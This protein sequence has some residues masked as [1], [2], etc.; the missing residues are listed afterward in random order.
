MWISFVTTLRLSKWSFLKVSCN[1][2]SETIVLKF[3]SVRLKPLVYLAF[4][5][6]LFAQVWLFG[7]TELCTSSTADTVCSIISMSQYTM[8]T[9]HVQNY[10]ISLISS[11]KVRTGMLSRLQGQMQVF[12]SHFSA[13]KLK[14]IIEDKYGQLF[15][16]KRQAYLVHVEKMSANSL[17][18]TTTFCQLF[19]QIKLVFHGEK[20]G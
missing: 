10:H 18:W 7:I 11:E 4:W 20:H 19:F 9:N 6:G 15:S 2:E 17:V 13:R 3:H 5:I 12:Q 16:L 8:P 1:V 14:F